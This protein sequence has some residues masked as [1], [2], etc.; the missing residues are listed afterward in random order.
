MC[1]YNF[2][3][4]KNIAVKQGV[5]IKQNIYFTPKINKEITIMKCKKILSSVLALCIV[6]SVSLIPTALNAR[7]EAQKEEKVISAAVKFSNGEKGVEKVSQVALYSLWFAYSPER[8]GLFKDNSNITSIEG[9]DWNLEY[10][11]AIS[12]AAAGIGNI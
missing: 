11:Y 5:H 4:T 6:L 10:E 3:A 8:L 12:D 7:A 1:G 9:T 2:T